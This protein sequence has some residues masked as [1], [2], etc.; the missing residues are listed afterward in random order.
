MQT[1]RLV[2]VMFNYSN[3]SDI[4]FEE[5]VKDIMEKS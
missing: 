1:K 4:E 5:L 2:M 3:L